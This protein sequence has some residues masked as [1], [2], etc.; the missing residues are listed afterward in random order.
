MNIYISA[1]SLPRSLSKESA[2]L[3]LVRVYKWYVPQGSLFKEHSQT[4]KLG[5]TFFMM[6][7]M[8]MMTSYDD[9]GEIRRKS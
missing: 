7:M 8:M 6:P 2:I 4:F 3:E 9:F 5:C 1:Y